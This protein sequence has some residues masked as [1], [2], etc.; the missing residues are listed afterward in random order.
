MSFYIR[1]LLSLLFVQISYCQV[2]AQNAWP[3][4]IKSSGGAIISVFEPQPEK[5][6]GNDVTARS[7]VSIRKT[8]DDEPLFGVMWFEAVLEPTGDNAA[9]V[10]AVSV[11]KSKFSDSDEASVATL[12]EAVETGIPAM[13]M[14]LDTRRLNEMFQQ[15]KADTES[16][17]NTAP[18]VI[19][20]RSNPTTLILLDGEPIEQ[21]DEDLK[22]VRVVNSPYLMLKN[23]DDKRYYLYGGNFWYSSAQIKSGWENVKI[24]PAKIKVVDAALKEQEAKQEKEDNQEEVKFT[25]PTDILVSTE[26]AELI[27]TEGEPTYKAVENSTLLYVDNSLEEIFKDVES[28]KNYI[29]LA[30][31]WYSSAKLQGPWEYVS[32]DKLPAAFASIPQGSEKDGVLASVAGTTAAEEA[33]MDANIPQTAKVDRSTVTC[34]VT[35]DGAP[36]FVRIENTNLLLAENSNI[37]VMQ[38][39]NNQYYALENGIWFKSNKPDGPWE[40][41]NERP[42]D[43]EKIPASSSAYNTKYVYIYHTTPQFVYVGYTPGYLGCYRFHRTI[44]WGTGWRYHPWYGHRYYPRPYTWGFG[45]MYSPWSGWCVSWGLS[46]NY[47][48]MHYHS[49]YGHGW[50]WFG[51]PMYRPPYRPWGWNGGY[52]GNRPSYRPPRH[53]NVTTNRPPNYN[54]RPTPSPRP[55]MRNNVYNNRPAVVTTDRITRPIAKPANPVGRPGNNQTVKPS[56]RPTVPR[57]KPST[58]PTTP[59]ARPA[60][61]PTTPTARPGTK[62][63]TPSVKPAP[64]KPSVKPRPQQKEPAENRRTRSKEKKIPVRTVE[65]KE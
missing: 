35:Y 44:V 7:A 27:Q 12:K 11:L 33:I 43:V 45:M 20:Y 54:T 51:P 48:W 25:T 17:I 34:T 64:S 2:N 61:K 29:L 4:E 65:K 14:K 52:Y 58:R 47:G 8:A 40:V 9:T 46:F 38:A 53:P 60:A 13:N 30:G 63:A 57:E 10:K 36:K 1:I 6:S 3:K 49:Y 19:Y 24:L 50:G 18:P 23:P 62:P 42:A 21:Q 32:S 56:T 55:A 41:A 15:E 26:P 39:P 22:M 31:R 37:T 28:Q 5:Y 59:S 16:G